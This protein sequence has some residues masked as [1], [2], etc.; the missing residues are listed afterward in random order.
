MPASKSLIAL[1]SLA[2]AFAWAQ[3]APVELDRVQV[4][5]THAPAAA[6]DVPASVSVIDR[7]DGR[8]DSL[9][10]AL[11]ERLTTVP[12]LLARDRRNYAQDEQISIRGF[13]TRASFGIR[14]VRLAIDGVPAT[15]PDGQGQVSHLPLAF[16]ERIEVLRGP[17]SVLYGNAAGGVIQVFTADPEGALA[18]DAGANVGP[19]ASRR[20]S[21]AMQGASEH[22]GGLLGA[23]HFRT[24]GFREHSAAERNLLHGKFRF[25]SE[26]TTATLVLD[27]LDA[28]NA[29]DPLGLD[30]AQFVADPTQAAPQ[31]LIFDT[32]KSVSQRQLG[33]VVEHGA[34][35]ATAYAGRREVEQF[36]AIP[37]ATQRNPLSN[38]GVV[39]LHSPYAGVDA[40]WT[41]AIGAAWSWTAGV[42]YDALRQDRRG[43]ENFVDGTL[44][45]RGALRADQVD[46]VD[47]LDPYVQATWIPND[48]WQLTA[49]ARHSRVR[50]RS[51]DHYIRPGNPD[52]SGRVTYS[53]TSPVLGVRWRANDA[54]QFYAAYGEGFETPTFNE[55]QYRSDGGSG[56]NFALQAASTRSA[57]VGMKVSRGR[58]RTELSLFQARTDDELTVGTSAGGRTTF[59]NAGRAQ[60]TG[61]ELS[62]ALPL[63]DAWLA[64]FAVT[65]LDAHFVDGFL[66][67]TA[68]PCTVPTLPVA[69]GTRIPGIPRTQAQA[70]VRWGEVSSGWH[71][72]V[73]GVYVDAVP[74]NNF[75]D[76]S[77]PSY[78]VFNASVGYGFEHGRVFVALDN[79]GDR[80]YAGSV[81]VN[82]AN[83]RYY[84]PAPGRGATV[85][86]ELHWR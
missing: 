17:F 62:G 11:S 38:G 28:P 54:L 30:R 1:T 24:D 50:F 65:W 68:A 10:A 75:G 69:A 61:L 35:R 77:A 36:L 55:L 37:V 47:A 21:L 84:E 22:F 9:G 41:G 74:V 64:E 5:A 31:A 76:E 19:D 7:D 43:Y 83:R 81:I 44:G 70:A 26:A 53:A 56:L 45:V 3:T 16:A 51:E 27:T 42:S 14:G 2:P 6:R 79:L 33:A 40:R 57:E 63:A 13:G 48:A 82:E 71:A 8:T 73:E 34:F 72:R 60:R 20:V 15:M 67:C 18:I 12:G 4:T 86:V 80:I 58:L 49:G 39:D 52:D 25:Q 85:G 32:R 59:Q 66:A 29:Q 78:A 46:R 23:Q